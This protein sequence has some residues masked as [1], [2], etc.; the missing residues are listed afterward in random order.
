MNKRINPP[1]AGKFI[2]EC[3][4]TTAVAKIF[5]IEL[6]S[7]SGWRRKGI[8]KGRVL[9][10]SILKPEIFKSLWGKQIEFDPPPSS[11]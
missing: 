6:A 3:G 10:L 4:G 9:T 7:V 1:L 2:D 5:E 11:T 8:P